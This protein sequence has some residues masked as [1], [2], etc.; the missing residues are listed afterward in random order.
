VA[1]HGP[2]ADAK[3]DSVA[4]LPRVR[5]IQD[6]S[7][8]AMLDGPDPQNA[9]AEVMRRSRLIR[10]ADGSVTLLRMSDILEVNRD[11]SVLGVG[12]IGTI[13]GADRARPLVPLEIDGPEHTGWRKI[14]DPVFAPKQVAK[15]ENEVRSLARRLLDDFVAKGEADVYD[16]FCG[17]LPKTIFLQLMGLPPSDVGVLDALRAT[18]EVTAQRN[19]YIRQAIDERMASGEHREDLLGWL[20]KVE[21]EGHRLDAEQI[22][23]VAILF[24]IAGL[25]TVSSSLACVI[26]RLARHPEERTRLVAAPELWPHAIEEYLRYESPV[27]HGYRLATED[28]E[29]GGEKIKANTVMHLS[30][31]AANLDEETFEHPFEVDLARPK[32]PHIAFASGFHRCLGSHLARMEL[33]IALEEFHRALPDYR[34]APQY[35]LRFIAPNPR[36]PQG[37]L[38]EWGPSTR[39]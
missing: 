32:N 7:L 2:T 11:R 39:D 6:E 28:L 24:V 22:L 20:L 36:H 4:S 38:L 27:T 31:S 34:L 17:P 26:G 3:P 18:P 25:D 12:A 29:V 21:R 15:L 16:L 37:L 8:L 35:E 14:L 23:D 9:Y 1:D 30:W 10:N 13:G 33:R 19:D 5:P